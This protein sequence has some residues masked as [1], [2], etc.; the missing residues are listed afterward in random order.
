[1]QQGQTG[2]LAPKEVTVYRSGGC[3]KENAAAGGQERGW[4]GSGGGNKPCLLRVCF[5]SQD[6]HA[7][8]SEPLNNK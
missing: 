6:S 5:T 7:R 8:G 2:F 4:R 3:R 1:M